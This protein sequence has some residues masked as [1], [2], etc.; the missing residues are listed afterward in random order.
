MSKHT[1]GP[2]TV[3]SDHFTPDCLRVE[4]PTRMTPVARIP[5][6]GLLG[7]KLTTPKYDATLIAAAPELYEAL[8]AYVEYETNFGSCPDGCPSC[9]D[10]D[11]GVLCVFRLAQAALVKAEGKP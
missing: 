6:T 9:D 1:P 4:A 7:S 8:A 3:S 2:W 10:D 11:D 5:L